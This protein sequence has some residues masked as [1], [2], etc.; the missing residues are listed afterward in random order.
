MTPVEKAELCEGMIEALE[1]YGHCT[2][3]YQDSEGRLCL[4]G[5]GRMAQHNDVHIFSWP[6]ADNRT[7]QAL[8]M[9][10]VEVPHFNDGTDVEVVV[11]WNNHIQE[12]VHNYFARHDSD[13]VPLN[14]ETAIEYVT[15][16]AKYWRE[17]G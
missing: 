6:A 7:A 1:K 2:G 3:D 14:K 17:Q 8:N 5:A 13:R 9:T 4:L 15:K 16:M 12:Y 11:V 10:R